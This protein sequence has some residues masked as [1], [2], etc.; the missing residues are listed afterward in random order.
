MTDVD[1]VRGEER[2]VNAQGSGLDSEYFI[3]RLLPITASKNS[4]KE[5][6]SNMCYVGAKGIGRNCGRH[7]QFQFGLTSHSFYFK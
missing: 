3:H 5:I 4:K 2:S 7:S 1:S 6:S